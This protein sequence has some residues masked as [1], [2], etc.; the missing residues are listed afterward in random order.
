M[1]VTV[2]AA[3]EAQEG[4]GSHEDAVAGQHRRLLE[5]GTPRVVL[6]PQEGVD[7]RAG[8]AGHRQR[9]HGRGAVQVVV[10]RA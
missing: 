5:L 3:W 10:V 8:G 9:G 4:G 1:K 6:D 2:S 7:G